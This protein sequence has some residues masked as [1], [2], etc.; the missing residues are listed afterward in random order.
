[1]YLHIQIHWS[2]AYTPHF[3]GNKTN[4][5][6]SFSMSEISAIVDCSV[7]DPIIKSDFWG[8]LKVT[9]LPDSPYSPRYTSL[10]ANFRLTLSK[11][12][13]IEL[14]VMP[15][16]TSL[17]KW[18][19]ANSLPSLMRKFQFCIGFRPYSSLFLQVILCILK[20]PI[21]KTRL[22]RSAVQRLLGRLNEITSGLSW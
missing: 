21:C 1:M 22:S 2:W 12:V 3:W 11:L 10:L 5:R 4:P 7:F 6:I 9:C 18:D 16:L 15:T 13:L 8:G 14:G 20:I 17:A 19:W